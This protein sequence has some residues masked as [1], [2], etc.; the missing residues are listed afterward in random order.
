MKLLVR[1]AMTAVALAA[2]A[3][4]YQSLTHLGALCGYGTLAWLYPLVVDLGAVA[5]C[6]AWLHTRG[7]QPLLMTWALLATS[8]GLNG[9]DHFLASTM[10]APSWW[11]IVAI[12]AVP[13]TV[14][15]CVVHLAVGIGHNLDVPGDHRLD[16]TQTCFVAGDLNPRQAV[17]GA[18]YVVTTAQP[19]TCDHSTAN[20][21]EP[22]AEEPADL[23]LAQAR[24]IVE[25]S[26]QLVGRNRLARELGISPHRARQLLSELANGAEVSA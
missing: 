18:N 17:A 3:L 9:T 12:A 22:R 2:A 16:G 4:S 25:H 15:G 24:K 23:L 6:A 1:V 11:L 20:E 21:P 19:A 26:D 10:L 13:P 7:R 14:L 8:V 5:S